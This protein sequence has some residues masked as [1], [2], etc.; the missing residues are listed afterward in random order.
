M[1]TEGN[2]LVA[3]LIKNVLEENWNFQTGNAPHWGH[4]IINTRYAALAGSQ[5]SDVM[6]HNSICVLRDCSVL[7]FP[8][9][10]SSTEKADKRTHMEVFYHRSQMRGWE[11]VLGMCCRPLEVRQGCTVLVP[12]GKWRSWKCLWIATWAFI[13]DFVDREM[14][15]PHFAEEESPDRMFLTCTYNSGHQDVIRSTTKATN[16]CLASQAGGMD[17]GWAG[18]NS[19]WVWTQCAML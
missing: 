14:H 6:L 2:K 7:L 1:W 4:H 3:Y 12:G 16:C 13:Y 9:G 15:Q 11:D 19:S 8:S 5:C 10:C 18:S 17:V